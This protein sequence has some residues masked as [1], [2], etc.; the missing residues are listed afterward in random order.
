M[1]LVAPAN[2]SGL[3]ELF[4]DFTKA[5]T[6]SRVNEAMRLAD[7]SNPES[8]LQ[9]GQSLARAGDLQTGLSLAQLGRQMQTE[10]RQREAGQQFHQMLG[11]ILGGGMQPNAAPPVQRAPTNQSASLGSGPLPA[12][13]IQNESGGRF[14]ARNDAVGSGGQVGHFGR[15][16]FGLARL[17]DAMAAGAIPQ[18]TTP[19]QFMANPQMQQA[20]EAWHVNDLN[21]QIEARGLTRFEGQTINGAP[22]TRQG[23]L[24]G[25]HLGGIGGV[26]RY[27]AS[28]GQFNPADANGTRIGDYVARHGGGGQQVAQAG[29][30]PQQPAQG[31]FDPSRLQ[32]AMP[33][34]IQAMGNPDLPAAQ[35]QQIQTLIQLGAQQQGSQIIQREDGTYAVNPRT[36]ESRLIMAAPPRAPLEIERRAQAAGLQPG[37]Q[38]FRDF[39]RTNGQVQNT[40]PPV[41]RIKQTDGS[42]VA[43]QWDAASRDWIPLRAPQG[44][45]A[46]SNP[47]LTE[48]Q[49]KDLVF[50]ERGARAL[51]QLDAPSNPNDPRSPRLSDVLTS[52]APAAAESI[53]LVGNTL[54]GI[55]SPQFQAARQAGQNFLASILRKDTGAAVTESEMDLYGR[56][57]L[58][59]VGDNQNT[60]DL[61]AD[62]RRQAMVAIRQG[63]GSAQIIAIGEN[64]MRPS[65]LPP[66]QPF[67]SQSVPTVGGSGQ[68]M[69]PAQQQTPTQ[70]PIAP[71]SY[72]FNPSTGRLELAR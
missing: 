14:D 38:E 51:S 7:L 55:V 44:G 37:S 40:A 62:A 32:Q 54:A 60:L 29:G 49:S 6:Q 11:G 42:E 65:P 39:V 5:R 25:A 24:A 36:N 64:I 10:Q 22:V 35:R 71:G 52:T 21:R 2:F 12:S 30:M 57:F 16:Q 13:L 67:G 8:L 18:G 23:I 27:L 31:G 50:Y 26:T 69:Q 33:M 53:P 41:Q 70:P 1:N 66:S 28:G 17:Q 34:L 47:R 3:G 15:A 4:N 61:K 48:Q 46:V 56:I 59:R 58:P 68:V 19:E 72:N 43:V 45:N 63:L 20:A 9:T